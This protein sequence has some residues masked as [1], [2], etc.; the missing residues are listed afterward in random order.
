MSSYWKG[1]EGA[2]L[3]LVATGAV[4]FAQLGIHYV[5]VAEIPSVGA[6]IFALLL[7]KIEF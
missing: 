1:E 2:Q 4:M 7:S 3:D 5:G 6:S